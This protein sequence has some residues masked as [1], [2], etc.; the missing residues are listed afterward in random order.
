LVSLNDLPPEFQDP[1]WRIQNLYLIRTKKKG[2]VK[3]AFN[4]CQDRIIPIIRERLETGKSIDHYD[5]KF[6]QGGVSTLWV[7]YYEDDTIW[8]S[9]TITGILAHK[10]ES[11]G[12]LWEIVRIAHSTMPEE[13]RPKPKTDNVRTLA[14]DNNSKIFVSQKIQS[15]TIH[16]LHVSEYPLCDALEIEQTLA[17]CP[18]NANVTLEGVAEG[19]NH[20]YDKWNEEGGPTK[21]FHPWFIQ[22]EYRLKIPVEKSHWTKQENALAK[23][24]KRDYGIEIDGYQ[25]AFRRK[26]HK[27]LKHLAMQEMA[28]DPITC[29]LSSGNPFFD[30]LKMKTLSREADEYLEAKPPAEIGDEYIMY[31]KP[32]KGDVYAAGADTAEGLIDGDFSYM[33]IINVTKKITAFRYRSRVPTGKFYHVLDHFGRMYNKALLAPE[34]NNTGHAVIQGLQELSYPNLFFEDHLRHVTFGKKEPEKTRKYGWETTAKS[35]SI[36]LEGIKQAVEG[37][38]TSGPEDFDTEFIV[39]DKIFL[40]ECFTFRNIDGKIEAAPGKHDDSIIAW[41]IAYQMF[42]RLVGK[43]TSPSAGIMMGGQSEASRTFG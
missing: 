15:T 31:E 21:L 33:A 5:L 11:L 13:F 18:P 41:A 38:F 24:A 39:L 26:K 9:N 25:I 23:I 30:N 14:F 4:P 27:D 3:M 20:A 36:A 37:E 19:M 32:I 34:L 7:L 16:N 40:Q 12:H 35:R 2:M 28:E 29:F 22:P 8:N 42:K 17:A 6:R 1:L 10:Q 43:T